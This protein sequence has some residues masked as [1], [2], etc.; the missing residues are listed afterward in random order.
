LRV[1]VDNRDSRTNGGFAELRTASHRL[2]GMCHSE[3]AAEDP[4]LQIEWRL[5]HAQNACIRQDDVW[6]SLACRRIARP[7]CCNRTIQLGWRN[8]TS[9]LSQRSYAEPDIWR[10]LVRHSEFILKINLRMPLR[11]LAT[12]RESGSWLPVLCP[13]KTACLAGPRFRPSR[14][15]KVRRAPTRT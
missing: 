12:G 10:G 2:R 15:P 8:Q 4:R 1:Q 5:Q 3:G 13:R 7:P 14:G 9:A 6:N 11:T